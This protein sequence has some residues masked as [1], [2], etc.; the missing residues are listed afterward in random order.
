[1]FTRETCRRALLLAVVLGGWSCGGDERARTKADLSDVGLQEPL[2]GAT[3]FAAFIPL[4]GQSL[5]EAA[6]FRFIVQTKPG[7]RSAPVEVR[8]TAAALASRGLLG[9][10]GRSVRLPVFA[11]YA[12]RTNFVTVAV[13]FD[14]GSE[15]TWSLPILTPA[16]VDPNGVYDHPTFIKP[17]TSNSNLGFSYIYL[18][19]AL[20]GPVV[21]DIDGEPR[22]VGPNGL[23]AYSSTFANGS[24]IIGAPDTLALR[25]LDLDGGSR[26]GAVA[27]PSYTAFHHDVDTGKVGMLAEF[28]GRNEDG[29]NIETIAAEIN[30][31]G[32]VLA[33]W[34]F[35]AIFA[36][37]MRANGDDPA[38]FVRPGVDWFHMN[39]AFYDARDDTIVASSRENFIVKV[40]YQSGSIV[41][42]FGDPTKYW[43]QFPSLR[44]K[45]L[46]LQAGGLYPLGQHAISLAPDGSLL[47]FNNGA[48]SFNQPAG[49][50][51][52][53]T[54]AYSAVSAY[55]TD[56]STM[57]VSEVWRFDHGQSVRSD[58]C[59]SVYQMPTGALLINYSTASNRTKN[60][61]VAVDPDRNVV[62]DIEYASPTPCVTSWNAR[63]IPFESLR[64]Q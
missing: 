22:W 5:Q 13:Q 35:A 56:T 28:D 26:S 63:S 7:A 61:I 27:A 54:R 60:R 49:V 36:K 64:I 8:Y 32:A 25:E 53:E 43:Y 42:L 30:R 38:A 29:R 34:D 1:M 48:P 20:S 50:P 18:K 52:G 6:E 17:L 16:Y 51:V 14:D 62:L 41:W 33:E 12:G 40:D 46:T 58:V 45:A 19:S 39:A 31:N 9:S 37:H 4:S 11:L 10:D 23:H 44:A 57:S 15:Q 3:A 59:S 2:P 47:L 24:F 21:I 55:R